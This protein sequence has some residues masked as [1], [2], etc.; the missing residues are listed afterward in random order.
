MNPY[1]RIVQAQEIPVL[2][3]RIE[4]E[5]DGRKVTATVLGGH[6]SIELVDQFDDEVTAFGLAQPVRFVRRR[7]MLRLEVECDLDEMVITTEAAGTAKRCRPDAD[8]AS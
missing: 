2:R 3:G 8:T 1:E 6:A 7:Q 4:L 5:Q